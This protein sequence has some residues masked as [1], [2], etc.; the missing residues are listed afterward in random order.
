M[1]DEKIALRSYV[2]TDEKNEYGD[3]KQITI[4]RTIWAEELSIGMKEFYQAQAPG[5]KPEIKFK[6]EDYLDYKGEEEVVYK[7]IVYKI[8]RT[9]KSKG[10]SLEITCYGGVH[11]ERAEVGDKS[12]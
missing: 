4:D 7:G 10:N 3:Y 5:Y 8:L 1:Y 2:T 12:N 9:Y 11:D 6:I